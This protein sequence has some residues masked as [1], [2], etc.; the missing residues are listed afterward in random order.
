MNE[1]VSV[2]LNGMSRFTLFVPFEVTF[3]NGVHQNDRG[4]QL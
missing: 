4:P 3:A 1:L 2:I